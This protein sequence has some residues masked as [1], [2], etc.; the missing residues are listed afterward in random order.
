GPRS[1]PPSS[2]GDGSAPKRVGD[3]S[4]PKTSR[5]T[6]AVRRT[7]FAMS[8][9]IHPVAVPGQTSIDEA[10]VARYAELER[11][12]CLQVLGVDDLADSPQAQCVRL[13]DQQDAYKV[14]LLAQRQSPQSPDTVAGACTFTMSRRDNLALAE[15]TFLIDPDEDPGEVLPLL[16]QHV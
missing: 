10:Q 12:H 8:L 11:R 4:A 2:V 6:R 1:S 13:A 9:T 3:G 14:V 5:R 7:L 15:G 16:W